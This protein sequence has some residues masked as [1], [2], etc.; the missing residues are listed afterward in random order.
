MG[1]ISGV[2]DDRGKFICIERREMQAMAQFIKKKVR[3]R[4]RGRGRGRLGLALTSTLT[5][6]QP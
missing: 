5:T 4:G 6:A 2:V 1:Y 3:D